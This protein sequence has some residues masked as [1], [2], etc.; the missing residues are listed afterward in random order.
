MAEPAQL[1]THVPDPLPGPTQPQRE[2]W[3]SAATRHLSVAAY[4]DSHFRRA[5]LTG[6]HDRPRRT[7]APSYGFD[8]VPVLYH[9]R[10]SWRHD[11]IRDASFT[12][13]GGILMLTAPIQFMTVA[14]LV[15]TVFLLSAW[16]TLIAGGVRLFRSGGSMAAWREWMVRAALLFVGGIVLSILVPLL[17]APLLVT[18]AVTLVTETP[19]AFAIGPVVVVAM[20]VLAGIS[21]GSSIVR[22]LSLDAIA[23]GDITWNDK[24]TYRLRQIGEQQYSQVSRYAGFR[25]Y[26]GAGAELTTWSFVQRLMPKDGSGPEMS[27]QVELFPTP[28]TAV[29]LL[30]HLRARL[31]GFRVNPE[32]SQ[33]LTGFQVSEHVFVSGRYPYLFPENQITRARRADVITNPEGPAR[34]A[35]ACQVSSWDGE[36]V[37]T[38]Y[39]HAS[40]QGGMLYLELSTHALTPTRSAYQVIDEIDGVGG[41]AMARALWTGVRQLGGDVL[42]AP[43]RLALAGFDALR[44][45]MADNPVAHGQPAQAAAPSLDAGARLSVRELATTELADNYFQL[46]D[47]FKFV[48]LVER[49]ILADLDDFL[50]EHDVDT[51]DYQESSRVVL[52]GNIINN[53]INNTG[54]GTVS[55]TDSAIGSGTKRTG[56]T[57]T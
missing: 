24:L 47:V 49:R 45:A 20:M 53:G 21:I 16:A 55:V 23:A 35:L 3:R 13:F 25:P 52:N 11:V 19:A 4:V 50:A 15:I 38:I 18:S 8:I 5:A 30:D 2:S 57:G 10:R 22:Q 27:R 37:A 51:S 48:K 26:L 34:H 17:L 36:I 39:L 33:R 54:S 12:G 32:P 7:V 6:V 43:A 44:A 29:Q 9:C 28:F 42:L 14:S 56:R 1:Q 40:V 46:R 41:A 31:E